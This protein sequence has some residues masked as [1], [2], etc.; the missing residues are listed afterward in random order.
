M[1]FI[2]TLD[3]DFFTVEMSQSCGAPALTLIVRSSSRR[4]PAALQFIFAS[5]YQED[6]RPC[7]LPFGVGIFISDLSRCQSGSW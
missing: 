5:H 1:R 4:F 6:S 2:P 3:F 7:H